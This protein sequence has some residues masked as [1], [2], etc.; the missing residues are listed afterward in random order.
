VFIVQKRNKV[1]RIRR[2][3][4]ILQTTPIVLSLFVVLCNITDILCVNLNWLLCPLFGFSVFVLLQLYRAS[5][6][7]YVSR[8]SR[9][10]YVSL[11]MIVT[12]ELL[13]EIFAL[14]LKGVEMQQFV[15]CML[16]VGVIV[17]LC[18]F[19]YDKFKYKL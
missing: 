8:W 14:S 10:L 7:L 19:I 9:V 16:I 3:I 17:S 1:R 12:T 5:R 2:A 15:F 6:L 11:I 18:T 13:D 4:R